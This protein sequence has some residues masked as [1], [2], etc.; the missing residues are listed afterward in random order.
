MRALKIVSFNLSIDKKELNN[1]L[2]WLSIDIDLEKTNT[3]NYSL[4]TGII[5]KKN[6]DLLNMANVNY[7]SLFFMIY[8]YSLKVNLIFLFQ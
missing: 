7:R 6:H 8:Y 2:V 1:N 5:R 4:P 3:S